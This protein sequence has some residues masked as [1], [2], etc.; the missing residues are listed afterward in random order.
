M[1]DYIT[2]FLIVRLHLFDTSTILDHRQVKA[3]AKYRVLTK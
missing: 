3:H 2:H 1:Y